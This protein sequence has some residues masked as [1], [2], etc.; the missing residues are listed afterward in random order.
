MA[1]AATGR[2]PASGK[3]TRVLI[4][5]DDSGLQS[6]MRWALDQYTVLLAGDR[7]SALD[8]VR[9][10]QPPI[11]VLDLGL[12]P[13]PD[14]AS[15]GLA[16]LREI[17]LAAPMTKIIV[18]S[19]NE[20]RANAVQA[21]GLGAYDFYAKPIDIDVLSLIIERA[22]HVYT[23]EEESRRRDRDLTET[24]LSGLITAAPEMLKVCRTIEKL[25]PTSVGVLLLGESGTGKDVLAR[26]IHDLSP[27]SAKPFVAINCAA[28]PENL[29]ESEL[30]GHERGAFTGAVRQT[31]GKI[32]LAHQGTLFL[33]EIGDLP[34]PLQ[35]KLLRFLQHRRFERVGGRQEIAVDIRLIS[36]TN[37]N[38]DTFIREGRF[39]ED[40]FYRLNEVRVD[41]PPLRG[42]TGDP[43]LLVNYFIGQFN[44]AHGRAVRGLAPDAIDTVM[45]YNWPGNVRE[46]ENRVK[47]AVI[48][49]ERKFITAADL[50]LV[51]PEE[52]EAPLDLREARE[53]TERL[54][55]Q[56]A[57]AQAQGNVT[58]AAKILGVSRP[59]LYYLVRHLNIKV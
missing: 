44:K 25:A 24:P 47:R 57:L 13:D 48:M 8:I 39:R 15:E 26:A 12:P 36:A 2:A 10:E 28:I 18:A 52:T 6:Q 9:A 54:V 32:E 19:G 34:L 50:D 5:E 23:L 41:I 16:T 49:A 14:G 11:V 3:K 35:A 42:R 29:L 59:T 20:E 55:I 38:I 51:P 30:F 1:V 43:L 53:R 4:V 27:R 7:E 17:L 56:R 58:Q 45:K 33:D 21:I 46:L 31:Q 40:L 37:Q 22:L